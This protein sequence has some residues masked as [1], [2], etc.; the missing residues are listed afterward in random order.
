MNSWDSTIAST[1]ARTFFEPVRRMFDPTQLRSIR[2]YLDAVEVEKQ[3]LAPTDRE[4]VA[5]KQGAT[6]DALRLDPYWYEVWRNPTPFLLDHI[7]PFTW[8]VYPVQVRIIRAGAHLV[9][10]HQDIAYQKLLGA[11]GHQRIM[12]CFI[13]LDEDPWRRPTIQFAR[14]NQAELEHVPVTEASDTP[15]AYI[16]GMQ[17]KAWSPQHQEHYTLKLGDCLL[18]GDLAIHRS[19]VSPDQEMRDRRSLEFRLVCPEDALD[20]KDYFDIESGLFVRTDGSSRLAP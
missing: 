11:R 18:F 19:F 4:K 9:P 2:Q 8:V 17:L 12:T 16:G 1:R 5:L 6:S 20:T 10:W 3:S 13:P 7:R 14:S 15:Y